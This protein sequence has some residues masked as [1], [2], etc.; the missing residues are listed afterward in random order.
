MQIQY[1]GHSAFKVNIDGAVLLFDPFL[2][3]NPKFTGDYEAIVAD[4]TH[5]LLTHGHN[6][7][8]G[9]TFDILKKT[10]ALLICNP[11]MGDFVELTQEGSNVHSMNYGG[12][13]DFG[14]FSVAMVSALHSASYITD[15]GKLI[16]GGNPAGLIV[17]AGTHRLYHMGDT[18]IFS[19]MALI[20][21]LHQPTIGLVPVGDNYTMGQDEAAL[22]VNRYFDFE[23]VIP[24]HYATFGLLDQS[25]E[26]FAAKVKKGRVEVMAPMASI[27]V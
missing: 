25:A 21:E 2:T 16:P 5:V 22:A 18:G 6:D 24:C 17:T 23:L 19:D 3:R 11:E 15:D 12:R 20:N 13:R 4:V 10:G 14:A 26:S 7:H 9:D 8:F 27:S 1:L